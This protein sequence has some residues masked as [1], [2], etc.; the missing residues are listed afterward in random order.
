MIRYSATL[1]QYTPVGAKLEDANKLKQVKVIS[2]FER[3]RIDAATLQIERM[4]YEAV[5]AIAW[6]DTKAGHRAMRAA[7]RAFKLYA[8]GSI[9]ISDCYE[10]EFWTNKS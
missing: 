4:A 5:E 8:S 2:S 9:K 3:F 6:R 7:S 1:M 10:I